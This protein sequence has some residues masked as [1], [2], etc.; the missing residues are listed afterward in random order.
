MSYDKFFDQVEDGVDP[1][2][3]IELEKLNT[4]TDEIN[5]L[6]VDLDEARNQFR[7]LLQESTS[8]IESCSKKLGSCIVKVRP[9]YDARI[10]AKEALQETQKAAISF[11]RANSAHAAAK[12]MVY[13][14]EEGLKAEGR[15]FDHAWQEMLN[16][17]TMRVNE[18]ESERTRC[19]AE[20]KRTSQNYQLAEM[21]VRT[22]QKELKR[23]I[24]KSRPYFELKIHY[25]QLLE[26]QKKKVKSLEKQVTDVK[27][28]YAHT[29]KNL[30]QI[31]D[32]IHK[33]RQKNKNFSRTDLSKVQEGIVADSNYSGE[34]RRNYN[35]SDCAK[36]T[37]DFHNDLTLQ[38]DNN[39]LSNAENES[40]T[41]NNRHSMALMSPLSDTHTDRTLTSTTTFTS[42]PD[43]DVWSECSDGNIRAS[44]SSENDS[45]IT[46]PPDT[47]SEED[48]RRISKGFNSLGSPDPMVPLCVP[49]SD[50]V[51]AGDSKKKSNPCDDLKVKDLMVTEKIVGDNPG[52]SAF[53][54]GVGICSFP[55]ETEFNMSFDEKKS[56]T[57]ANESD[58]N[59]GWTEIKLRSPEDE[60]FSTV[61]VINL[62]KGRNELEEFDIP[63]TPL[64]EG[65]GDS[66][67]LNEVREN[68][69]EIDREH[70]QEMR[71]SK[72]STECA[73]K[74][75]EDF[76]KNEELTSRSL[77]G[78]PKKLNL[79]RQSLDVLWNGTAS[80]KMKEILSQ[81]IMKLNISS[82]TE[83]RASDAKL[84]ESSD[85]C[86]N[87]S[88]TF[89][90][91][92]DESSVTSQ[93]GI[94]FFNRKNSKVGDELQTAGLDE[95]KESMPSQIG[96]FISR[97]EKFF[98]KK[99]PSPLEKTLNYLNADEDS[100]SDNE[101]LASL[102]TLTDEQL[103]SL[104][105]DR[106]LT[107]IYQ[108]II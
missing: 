83:R 33:I 99:V 5:K 98:N 53:F 42:Q 84:G 48:I 101:S 78:T 61:K 68:K 71:E 80:E 49:I 89:E 47:E 94:N 51:G 107:E 64:P 55:I 74:R 11:E 32:E 7:Q 82:L 27:L 2:V 105:L 8:Q 30:E 72:D 69:S 46:G 22:L 24:T 106:D 54:E 66:H 67:G 1:R 35:L 97:K 70:C 19:E 31:S 9:Y 16:H 60:I 103:S 40:E 4:S 18:S 50:L 92:N 90:K 56:F 108:D 29:L 25:N 15:T 17:A 100:N 14:A 102:D 75:K 10:Q 21:R 65:E 52:R 36:T 28:T 12:E 58:P 13:L 77:K 20:H 73:R 87:E 93:F 39:K 79:R 23:A 44:P 104:I 45:S 62:G 85:V 34:I 57:S 86:E 3:Q 26:K 95:K 43:T 76:P 37:R 6:E 88:V 41:G 59:G 96:S 91:G 81:S 63:Y 38:Y